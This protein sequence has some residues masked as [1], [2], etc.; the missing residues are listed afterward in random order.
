MWRYCKRFRRIRNNVSDLK[1]LKFGRFDLSY[2]VTLEDI[3]KNRENLDFFKNKMI[4]IEDI[5][6][7][8][9]KIIINSKELDKFLNGVKIE[10]ILKN[11]NI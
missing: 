4:S 3:E 5:F 11:R 8:N 7:S 1:E 2:S 10:T 6:E 9:E